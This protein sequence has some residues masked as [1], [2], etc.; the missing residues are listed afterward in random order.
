MAKVVIYDVKKREIVEKEED[1]ELPETPKKEEVV[2]N[3]SELIQMKKDI[4]SI[5]E[6]IRKIHPEISVK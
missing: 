3:F 4:Q 6:V 2:I 1:I 5:K